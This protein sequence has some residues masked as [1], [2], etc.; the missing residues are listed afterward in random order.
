MPLWTFEGAVVSDRS[1]LS[2]LSPTKDEEVAQRK[3]EAMFICKH[4]S[5]RNKMLLLQTSI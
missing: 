4:S 1:N 2:A 5:H 3:Q